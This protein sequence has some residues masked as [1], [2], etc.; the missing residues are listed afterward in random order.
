M[1]Y[2]LKIDPKKR[3]GSRFIAKVRKEVVAAAIDEKSASGL[4]Q[5][6]LANALGVHRSVITRLLKG[7]AN[8]TLRSIGELAWALGW[9]PIFKMNRKTGAHHSNAAHVSNTVVSTKQPG[10]ATRAA[11]IYGSQPA[12]FARTHAYLEAAE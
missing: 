4:T 11:K 1:S 6:D 8:L 9:E 3:A 5:Q 7:D 10:T 12:S 2:E